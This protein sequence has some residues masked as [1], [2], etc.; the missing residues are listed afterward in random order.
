VK[1]VLRWYADDGSIEHDVVQLEAESARDSGH[2]GQA[3]LQPVMLG[4]RRVAPATDLAQAR[5]HCARQLASL[6]PAL[7]TLAA[8]AQPFQARISPQL[9]ALAKSMDAAVT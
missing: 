7:R 4:G 3:L 6:P 1:Q 8:A 2:A 9:Q 5:S